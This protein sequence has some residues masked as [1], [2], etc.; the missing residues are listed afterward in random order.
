MRLFQLTTFIFS[1]FLLV[2]S[3]IYAVTNNQLE[4][5]A[6]RLPIAQA[7][8]V[9]TIVQNLIKP[10]Y[11]DMEKA[12]ILA[13][14]VT[15]QMQKNG[16]A[17][18]TIK[19]ATQKQIPANFPSNPDVLKTRIGTSF[20]YAQLYQQLCTVAGLESVIIDGYAGLNVQAPNRNNLKLQTVKHALHQ[21]GILPNFDMQ[22]YE[23]AWN[24]VRIKD[25]WI[26]VDTYWMYN[27]D[28]ATTARD[29]KTD[30]EMERFLS[31]REQK[32]PT[33]SEIT[34]GKTINN[35][36]FDAKPRT[37]IK[38]HFPFDSQWQLL[39]TPVTLTS[40]VH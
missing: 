33:L 2:S 32:Q 23:A 30:R 20:D 40:F 21:T 13:Y 24:A 19:K 3:P 8:S 26:L 11:T 38:T 14:F 10:D 9:E 15:Y 31:K 6:K 35:D 12:R 36:Y 5:Y 34:K 17:D 28:K 25:K 22:K 39:P 18:K 29:I 1:S 4:S 7:E 37:F 27:Q 16:Y